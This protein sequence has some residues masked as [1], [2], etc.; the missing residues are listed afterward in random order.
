MGRRGQTPADMCHVQSDEER[1]QTIL[2]Q[3]PV[4]CQRDVSGCCHSSV[5]LSSLATGRAVRIGGT[6]MLTGM[7]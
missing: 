4:R 2:N 3:E 6:G 7:V 1:V 5:P